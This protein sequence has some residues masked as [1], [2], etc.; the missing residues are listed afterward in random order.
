MNISVISKQ[1]LSLAAINGFLIVTIGAFGAH[2]LEE[3]ISP[4]LLEVFNTGVQYHMFHVVAL[5]TTALLGVVS[6]KPT[7]LVW[8]NVLFLAGIILFSGSLYVLAL[9]G[10]TWLG[11]ITPVGGVAFLGGWVLLFIEIISVRHG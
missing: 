2:L 6:E 11:M 7:K 10:V 3:K 4:E 9:T 5:I 8:C 1:A